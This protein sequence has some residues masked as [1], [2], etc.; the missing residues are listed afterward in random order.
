[1]EAKEGVVGQSL[2]DE[3]AM[4]NRNLVSETLTFC[5]SAN[6]LVGGLEVLSQL[7]ITLKQTTKSQ[8]MLLLMLLLLLNCIQKR[9]V[10]RDLFVVL[11]QQVADGGGQRGERR[12]GLR[13]L[14]PTA[15]H[16]IKTKVRQKLTLDKMH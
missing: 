14:L 1:M 15:C 4:M 12:S 6:R 16:Q 2:V 8:T 7:P 10:M 5:W 3:L 13:L 11:G 9:N